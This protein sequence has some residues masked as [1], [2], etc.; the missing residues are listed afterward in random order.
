MRIG[1]FN[2][3]I[4]AAVDGNNELQTNGTPKHGGQVFVIEKFSAKARLILA[5][6]DMKLLP[7]SISESTISIFSDNQKLDILELEASQ[8][9]EVVS[10]FTQ[11]NARL[12]V[13][14][15]IAEKFSPDQQ[16]TVINV[17]LPEGINS[18][19]DLQGFN[20]R[21]DAIFKKFNITGNFKIV[22]FDSGTE[23]YQI[24]V[25]NSGLFGFVISAISL[26]L[27]AIDFRD[28]RKGSDDLRLA[29]KALDAKT[30]DNKVTEQKLLNGMV[31]EKINEDVEKTVDDLGC[32]DNREKP[33]TVAMII[34]A[35]KDLIKEIDRGTEFHLSLNPPDYAQENGMGMAINIDYKSI[36]KLETTKMESKQ[37]ETKKSDRDSDSE[38]SE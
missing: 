34:S 22:G 10:L 38:M 12:P 6:Q 33:E 28:S 9:T 2:Q 1:R 15:D 20:K 31:D 5:L 4:N 13:Y 25:D 27:Q 36:P 35:V 14:S 30:P 8:H 17:K 26:S 19:D 32:P 3:I 18:I 37:I 23:W 7:S 29:K 16:E 11:V 21:L 24:L